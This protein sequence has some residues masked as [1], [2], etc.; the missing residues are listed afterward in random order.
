MVDPIAREKEI[1]DIDLCLLVS[2]LG[3]FKTLYSL[4]SLGKKSVTGC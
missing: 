2:A 1:V 4:H 3:F